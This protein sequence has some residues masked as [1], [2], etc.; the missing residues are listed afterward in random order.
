MFPSHIDVCVCLSLLLSLKAMK[1]CSLVRIRKKKKQPREEKFCKEVEM[2][3][4]P[5]PPLEWG[6]KQVKVRR[7]ESGKAG[8]ARKERTSQ[9]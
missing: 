2:Q 1:E 7:G 6:S 3:I 8:V 4:Q 5:M 9:L